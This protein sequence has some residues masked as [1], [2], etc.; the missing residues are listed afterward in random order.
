MDVLIESTRLLGLFSETAA[1]IW[2]LHSDQ[3]PP[4]L[5]TSKT[6]PQYSLLY[7]AR[8]MPLVHGTQGE[9]KTYQSIAG[10]CL[11]WQLTE[12]SPCCTGRTAEY[13]LNFGCNE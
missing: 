7:V 9:H 6:A 2:H 3:K 1:N 11:T 8:V 12:W 13:S 5:Q 4:K 10:M